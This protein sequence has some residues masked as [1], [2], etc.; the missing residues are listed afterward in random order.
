MSQPSLV[1]SLLSDSVLRH[2]LPLCLLFSSLRLPET[3]LPQAYVLH[4]LLSHAVLC[5]ALSFLSCFNS[6]FYFTFPH[7]LCVSSLASVPQ[8]YILYPL[9]SHTVLCPTSLSFQSCYNLT[10][11]IMCFLFSPGLSSPCAP[12]SQHYILHLILFSSNFPFPP[13]LAL[14][15][16]SIS[17]CFL[18]PFTR[19]GLAQRCTLSLPLFSC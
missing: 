17:F 19:L 13:C 16:L 6:T 14:I 10:F 7:F 15:Q 5:P 3:P 4:P 1:H 12:A 2:S 9:L 8:S 18:F 11:H